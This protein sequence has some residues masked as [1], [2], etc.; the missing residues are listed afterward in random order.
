[1]TFGKLLGLGYIGVA[2]PL[3]KKRKKALDM[4]ADAAFSPGAPELKGLVQKR[5]KPFDAVVDAVGD[6]SIINTGLGMIKLGGSICVYGVIAEEVVTVNKGTG[7]YN[8]NLYMHQWPTRS[9]ERAAQA[10]LCDW[11]R[12]GKIK[13]GDFLTHEFDLDQINDAL[14]AVKRGEVIKALL[15]Y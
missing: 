8:F 13:P 2:D 3:E 7:P 5:G 1:M 14:D 12:A 6:S 10:P 9:R 15:R 11:I 4:G